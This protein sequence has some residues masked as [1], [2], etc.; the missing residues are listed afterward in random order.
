LTASRHS[1]DAV[2]KSDIK[3][4]QTVLKDE[5]LAKRVLDATKNNSN[6]KKRASTT[7][8]EGQ[9]KRKRTL[10]ESEPLTPQAIE[11]SLALP[12][13]AM[14]ED[15]I[16]NTVLFTNRAPLVLAF[17]VTLLKYTMPEQP[18]SARLSL[19]QALV[20]MNSRSKAVSIGLESGKSAEDEGWAHGQ[21]KVKIMGR[22]VPVLKRWDYQWRDTKSYKES[23]TNEEGD[24]HDEL[25]E[26]AETRP[27]EMPAL[28]GLDLE[29]LRSSNG[30]V[31]F[32]NQNKNAGSLP[33]FNAE[34]ARSY[35]LKSFASAASTNS[36]P[37]KS[38]KAAVIAKEKE[39]NLALLLRSLDILFQ[40]WAPTLPKDELDR[41]A[42]SWYV[43]VRPD[44]ESGV[45]GWGG[46]GDVKLEEILNLRKIG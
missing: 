13:S 8:A 19:G 38:K 1:C 43:R 39:H 36:S 24:L 34:S 33:I 7:S 6:P 44:V 14:D 22:D 5:K 29:A 11:A 15:D 18:L 12:E 21:P 25:L 3:T 26:N 4:L 10:D 42:W 28:W 31:T 32:T 30:P 35:L 17:A 40:S 37:S 45:A 23:T 9:T 27:E 41:R 16:K 20:S 2:A 46:K